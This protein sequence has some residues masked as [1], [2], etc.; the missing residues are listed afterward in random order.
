M[1]LEIARASIRHGFAHARPL[2]VDPGGLSPELAAERASFVTL[3]S[4]G[5]LRGCIGSARAFRP[6]AE[7]IAANAFSSAFEDWRFPPVTSQELRFLSIDLSILTPP[8]PIAFTS[9]EDL[10]AQLEPGVDGLLIQTQWHRGLFLPSVWD[11]LP[12]PAEFLGQLKLKAGLRLRRPA[13]GLCAFRFRTEC[14][15]ET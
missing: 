12:D 10:A 4:Q 14:F 1:L 9:E 15:G 5:R 8:E 2:P 6:L 13:I 3:H 7:D 11:S